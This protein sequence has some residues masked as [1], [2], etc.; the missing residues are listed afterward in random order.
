MSRVKEFDWDSFVE[1]VTRRDEELGLRLLVCYYNFDHRI[2]KIGTMQNDF[3][4][5]A[6]IEERRG[7]LA[8]VL[9]EMFGHHSGV[10]VEGLGM[11]PPV[12]WPPI[13]N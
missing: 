11:G 8:K 5:G 10:V 13:S 6:Y 4:E 2:L 7:F 12:M 9:F 1:E 3:E